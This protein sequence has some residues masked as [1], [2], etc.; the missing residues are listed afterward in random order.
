MKQK[1]P[2]IYDSNMAI[3]FIVSL[4]FV[5]ASCVLHLA[6]GVAEAVILLLLFVYFRRTA[7]RRR[8]RIEDYLENVADGIDSVE[9]ASVLTAPVGMLVFRPDTME[10]LWNNERFREQATVR[11]SLFGVRVT[12]I[13]PTF[14]ARWLLEGKTECPDTVEVNGRLFRIYGSL[15]HPTGTKH[16]SGVLLATTYWVDITE[17]DALHSKIE[18]E[19]P[20]VGVI[21]IDNYEELTKAGTEAS[22]SAVLAQID[23]KL[24][25][26]V[27]GT[28]SILCRY[29]RNRYLLITTAE[30]YEKLAKTRFS[31]LDAVRGI[32]T[33]DG[34]AATLSIGIG[35]EAE[36]FEALFSHA[37]L[38]IDMALSR[39]GD[40]VVV[41]NK[42]DFEFYGG[43]NKTSEKR[44]KVKSRVMAHALGELILDASH[45]YVMGHKNADMDAIGAAAGI[46]AI[47][48]KRGK[49]VNI[50]IDHDG[51][52]AGLMIERLKAL[53]EYADVFISGTDAFIQSQASA[54]LVVVD[55]NRPDMVESEQLLDACNRV[56]VIDHHRR[57]ANYIESAALNYHEPYASSASELVAELV[58]YLTEP[59]DLLH[60]EAEALL[61]G[62]ILDTKNFTM[63]TGSR[64]FEA[65]AMLRRSGAETVHV[66]E[67]FQST[68][69]E[70][71]ERYDIIRRAEIVFDNIAMAAIHAQID[72]VSAAKAADEL[73]ALSGIE[74]SFVLF[75]HN[76]GV[77]I[78]AR[79]LGKINVQLIMEQLG[80]GGNAAT[81]GAQVRGKTPEEVMRLLAE[82]IDRYF[83]TK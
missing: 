50:V 13:I 76:E 28:N 64:T 35:K 39:G 23:E 3:Y 80:G 38:S 74:A 19:H 21:M 41:R 60:T 77:N 34:V 56:A 63:R 33:G 52:D 42:N 25:E 45:I 47:A 14:S 48:R 75:E 20:V 55:T 83:G 54:L 46:C 16:G 40:Q 71:I 79:S 32:V 53:P 12:D 26:W 78:S 17:I 22:R 31:V 7:Q 67:M 66:H 11:E 5:A 62:I 30:Q 49:E 4:L 59:G 6:L 36:T 57:A 82:A 68:L 61:A 58:Q 65:A 29:D 8:E 43:K 81:A 70:T 10:L 37:T 73:L 69:P 72:R 9:K 24:A 18:K 1:K 27:A 2:N 44:T 15:S 51:G